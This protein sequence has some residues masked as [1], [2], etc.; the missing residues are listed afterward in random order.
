MKTQM[1][2][3][4]RN[5]NKREFLIEPMDIENSQQFIDQVLGYSILNRQFEFISLFLRNL[6]VYAYPEDILLFVRDKVK[7]YSRHIYNYDNY[8]NALNKILE[9]NDKPVQYGDYINSKLDVD[10]TE[11]FIKY[12]IGNAIAHNQFEFVSLFLRN[13]AV[14]IF[15]SNILI[16]LLEETS[17]HNHLIPFRY[18]FWIRTKKIMDQRKENYNYQMSILKGKK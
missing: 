4:S 18:I 10:E 1:N 11:K 3:T 14:D 6:S 15:P 5:K 16:C 17:K 2:V 13:I 9:K 8:E 12:F 7:E